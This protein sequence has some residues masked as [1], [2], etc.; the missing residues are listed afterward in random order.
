MEGVGHFSA[1][2]GGPFARGGRGGEL[3]LHGGQLLLW[4]GFKKHYRGNPVKSG[5]NQLISLSLFF[6]FFISS[7]AARTFP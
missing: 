7:I 5:L 4:G 2:G 3:V 6:F 1:G